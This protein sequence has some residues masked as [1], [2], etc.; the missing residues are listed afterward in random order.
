MESYEEKFIV[1]N[2]NG[3]QNN[4]INIVLSFVIFLAVF[5]LIFSLHIKNLKNENNAKEIISEAI[6][7][8][9]D[10]ENTA[11]YLLNERNTE[12][13]LDESNLNNYIPIANVSF[14][15]PQKDLQVNDLTTYL[16]TSMANELYILGSQAFTDSAVELSYRENKNRYLI[17]NFYNLLS[18]KSLET[19]NAMSQI[20]IFVFFVMSI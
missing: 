15:K 18:K 11:K 20:A 13:L 2:K 3:N 8:F 19:F 6:S 10:I 7:W 1:S 16:Q 4:L 9:A 17:Y 14:G 5:T 12:I